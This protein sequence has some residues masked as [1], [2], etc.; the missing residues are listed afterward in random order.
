[1]KINKLFLGTMALCCSSCLMYKDISPKQKDELQKS[2]RASKNMQIP[3]SWIFDREKSEVSYDWFSELKD[4]HL[5]QLISESLQFNA[6]ILIAEEKLNQIELAMQIAGS[7][8]YPSVNAVAN[9]HNN[10]IK[11]SHIQNLALKANWEL[12]IW[13]KNKAANSANTAKYFSA[14]FQNDKLKQSVAAMVCKAYFLSIAANIQQAKVEYFL[15]LTRDLEKIYQVRAKVGTSNEIDLSNIKAEIISLEGQLEKINNANKEAKRTL[16]LLTGKYPEGKINTHTDFGKLNAEIPASFPLNLLENRPDI[17]ASQY[18]I[19]SQFYEVQEAK[20]A[21]LPSLSISAS[22]GGAGTN[23]SAL[24][25][26][27]SNPL[28]KVGGN[29][30]TPI[31]NG[32]ALKKNVEIKNSEQKMAV[33]QYAKTLL[34]ALNEVE[35]AMANV[36]SIEKQI[37]YSEKAI[38]ELEKNVELTKKQIQ[39]G[40]IDNFALIQ[41]Q[42]D[43]LRKE[44]AFIDLQLQNRV[45]RINLYMAL[46]ASQFNK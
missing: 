17:L 28:I 34:N 1:M 2:A 26:L 25:S 21:Q 40:T 44:M 4:A 42:R 3:D 9:T 11:G 19:E 10:L 8:L 20:A 31:F 43:L 37:G 29:L 33:E 23:I 45:E 22:L 46:G 5:E 30:A 6:D 14:K 16:E 36:S 15:Q 12:D 35:G 24:N 39:I 13:G 7:N 38:D 27:Y 41:K 18:Q 32:G